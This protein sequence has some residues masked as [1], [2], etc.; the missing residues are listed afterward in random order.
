MFTVGEA[1]NAKLKYHYFDEG[2]RLTVLSKRLN[3]KDSSKSLG[4]WKS[5]DRHLAFVADMDAQFLFVPKAWVRYILIVKIA[6]I[7]SS[8]IF[9]TNGI[10]LS[11]ERFS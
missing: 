4:Q 1:Y 11:A 7:Q 9:D 5:V 10:Y 6:Q 3:T 2:T 8:L